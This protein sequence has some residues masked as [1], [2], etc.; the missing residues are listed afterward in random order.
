[1]KKINDIKTHVKDDVKAHVKDLLRNY[2]DYE[3]ELIIE[4]DDFKSDSFE[5]DDLEKPSESDTAY[6]GV[7]EEEE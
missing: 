2:E 4:S 6:L 1:M 7:E 5:S 3:E